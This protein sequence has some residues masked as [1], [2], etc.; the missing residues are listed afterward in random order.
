MKTG[1]NQDEIDGDIKVF[2][3]HYKFYQI[4]KLK[5]KFQLNATPDLFLTC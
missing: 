2:K 4:I 5:Y 3:I 1:S